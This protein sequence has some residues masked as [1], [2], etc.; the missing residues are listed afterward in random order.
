M[1]YVTLS[2]FKTFGGFDYDTE[3]VLLQ[4]ILDSA[5]TVIDEYTGRTFAADSVSSRTFTKTVNVPSRFSGTVLFLDEDLAD[6]ATH[7]T[8]SPTVRYLPEN[9]TPYYGIVITEDAW[10]YPTAVSYTH[11]TLPTSDLV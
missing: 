5:T 8:D 10:A 3:D 6:E 7:I 11:L 2:G 9:D 1:S 4:D